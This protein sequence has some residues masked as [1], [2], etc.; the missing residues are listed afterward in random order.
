MSR[1]EKEKADIDDMWGL[2]KS[3]IMEGVEKHIPSRIRR[4]NNSLPWMNRELRRLLRSKKR[5]YKKAKKS[6]N[7]K[8]YR[9]IQKECRRKMRK[10][11]NDYLN[12]I[13]QQGMKENNTKPFWRFVKSRRQDN[14]G[15]APLKDGTSL[16]SDTATK[17]KLLLRQFCSVFTKEDSSQL[18]RMNGTPHP[19]LAE[20]KI[21][22]AGVA[23]L[24]RNLNA[25]KASGPDGIPSQVLKHCADVLA[26]ALTTIF[27]YSLETGNLP[28]DWLTANIA[29]VFKKG[30]R[31]KAENYRPVSLTSVACKTMEHVIC[32]HL[33]NHLEQHNILTNKK[34]GFRSGFSC[35]TQLLTTMDD[36]LKSNNRGMQTDV[37][38]LD[39]SKAFDTVPHAKLLHKLQHYGI[40]GPVLGWISTFLTRRTMRV[41][42]EGERS[43]EAKVESGVPQGTVLGPLLFLCHINDLP[44]TVSSSV[45]LFADDCLL[46]REIRSFLDHITLQK[47]LSR[48]EAWARDWGMRFNAKKCYVLPTKTQSTFFYK[49]NDEALAHVEQNPYL[50]LTISSDL[51]WG[52]HITNVCKK[53]GSTLGFLRRNLGSCSRECR[54][55]AYISLLRSKLEYGASV[56]DPYLKK[57]TDRLERIQ[58]QAARFIT[59]D[60]KSRETGCVTK[61]LN[62]LNLKPLQERRKQ[63]RLVTFYKITEGLIPALPPEQFLTPSDHGKSR[64][65]IRPKVYTDCV[66]TNLVARHAA[67]HSKAYKVPDASSEQYSGSFFVKTVVE[68]NQLPE[69]TVQSKSAAAFS[70]ALGKSLAV[71]P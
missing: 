58:R 9:F 38:I 21:E 7:W 40:R 8:N 2:F 16:I 55:L 27:N 65:T 6:Q 57:D 24:L 13:I 20:L 30:D 59:R 70:T 29:S 47:D 34:H 68:W 14:I 69:A 53:A 46:Y 1:L 22:V 62:D 26:P 56:W 28:S 63:Q 10:A 50:G 19:D 51:K 49:L 52:V 44:D 5:H 48:L 45:R 54:R 43:E 4:R 71:G 66:T 3:T 32:H 35:E 64:R 60:Y 17:A 39:F 61:M 23:K 36:L 67:V 33:R 25:S 41:V 37:I 31:N 18:P 42:L 12:D 15:V 11:E